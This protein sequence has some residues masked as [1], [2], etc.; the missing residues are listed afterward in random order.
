MSSSIRNSIDRDP[1]KDLARKLIMDLA[2]LAQA[3]ADLARDL[4]QLVEA[5][6]GYEPKAAGL[7]PPATDA[8]TAERELHAGAGCADKDGGESAEVSEGA[9]AILR[10]AEA[11]VRVEVAPLVDGAADGR[12]DP[13]VMAEIA[14]GAAATAGPVQT[15]PGDGDAAEGPDVVEESGGVPQDATVLVLESVGTKVGVL[16]DQV[17]HVGSLAQNGSPESIETEGGRC[18]LVSLGRVLNG[19]SSNERYYVV[20]DHEGDRV[21]VACE[22]MLGLGPLSV[23]AAAGEAIDWA[24]R[25]GE[26]DGVS[27]SGADDRNGRVQVIQVS[28]LRSFARARRNGTGAAFDDRPGVV[29]REDDDRDR[30]GPLRALV[31]VRYLPA[32]VAICRHLRGRG[33]QVGEAAGLEAAAVSL[34]LGR[35]DALF[36]EVRGNGESEENESGLLGRV[37]DRA[38]PVVRVGSR[39]SGLPQQQG[40]A[41]MFPFA[42]AE[43]DGI[44]ARILERAGA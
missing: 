38:I 2:R 30:N 42:E 26:R 23:A 20:L 24:P 7:Q 18:D 22:R 21:A 4:M 35:W 19:E 14:A 15:E 8:H 13:T 25:A 10:A 32:R 33:W 11:I 31:A 28:L 9:E 17:A 43:L 34:D 44:L 12:P 39:I 6:E 37:A 5:V 16:W 41:V 3:Q 1:V 40:P 36:L 27:A 29:S